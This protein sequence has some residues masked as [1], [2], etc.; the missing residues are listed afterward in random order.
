MALLCHAFLS[1]VPNVNAF[2]YR[3]KTSRILSSNTQPETVG[4]LLNDVVLLTDRFPDQLSMASVTF[5]ILVREMVRAEAPLND[6]SRYGLEGRAKSLL[7]QRPTDPFL[8]FS[9]ALILEQIYPEIE[10]TDPAF[11]AF[12]LSMKNGAFEGRLIVPRATFCVRQDFDTLQKP[13]LAA[14]MQQF[15]I[16][17]TALPKIF[18]TF[19]ETYEL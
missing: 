8:W 18:Q 13:Y 2:S 3:Q 15:E 14:C 16:F 4:D 11:E 17:E 7:A 10:D 12:L 5:Q 19:K 6:I 1:F 9:Y